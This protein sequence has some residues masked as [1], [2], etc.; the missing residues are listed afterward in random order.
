MSSSVSRI[1]GATSESSL[2]DALIKKMM[3]IL[4]DTPGAP[5]IDKAKMEEKS[6][7]TMLKR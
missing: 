4:A 5:V 2:E 6:Y 7:G 3:D 1:V